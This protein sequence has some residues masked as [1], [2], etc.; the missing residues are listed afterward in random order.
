MKCSISNLDVK[1][2]LYFSEDGANFNEKDSITLYPGKINYFTATPNSYFLFKTDLLEGED[3]VGDGE[4]PAKYSD[5][6]KKIYIGDKK[7]YVGTP[8]MFRKAKDYLYQKKGA[9]DQ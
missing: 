5:W 4:V 8:L 6:H 7:Y 1:N 2:M 3:I 9:C